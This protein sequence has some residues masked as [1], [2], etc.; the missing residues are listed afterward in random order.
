MEFREVNGRLRHAGRLNGFSIRDGAGNELPLIYRQR[1]SQED[2]NVVE[3]LFQGKLPEEA[4]LYYGA[5]RNPYVNLRDEA[6]MGAPAFG[7]MKIE[8]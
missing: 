6:G 8:R 7:P 4:A 1:V 5:G 3:L 2:P